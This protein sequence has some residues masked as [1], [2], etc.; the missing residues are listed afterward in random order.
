MDN[1]EPLVLPITLTTGVVSIGETFRHYFLHN[2]IAFIIALRSVLS[3]FVCQS[4]GD[5]FGDC[6]TTGMFPRGIQGA[7]TAFLESSIREIPLLLQPRRP[8]A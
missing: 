4:S 1:N 6:L 8:I 5:F 2:R 3:N 7:S